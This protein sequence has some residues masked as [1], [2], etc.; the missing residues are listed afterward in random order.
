VTRLIGLIDVLEHVKN[1]SLVL[2]T[3]WVFPWETLDLQR[4][5]LDIVRL[6][7]TDLEA[8]TLDRMVPSELL[9]CSSGSGIKLVPAFK[10]LK[11]HIAELKKAEFSLLDRKDENHRLGQPIKLPLLS[12]GRALRSVFAASGP[13]AP[14]DAPGE[15]QLALKELGHTT[16]KMW[17]VLK[18]RFAAFG[19][20]EDVHVR[21]MG[22]A[23]CLRRMAFDD[24]GFSMN[25]AEDALRRLREWFNSR[26]RGHVDILAQVGAQ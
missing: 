13:A 18:Q 21:H 15:V 3:V 16:R 9:R 14:V 4:E 20:G 7:A 2:Q 6:L 12:E 8:G 10:L 23:F 1:I 26:N 22:Q 19:P 11:L 17:E 24:A 25:M 5:R